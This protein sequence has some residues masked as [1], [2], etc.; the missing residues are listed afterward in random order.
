MRR[1]WQDWIA[2]AANLVFVVG[3]IPSIIGPNK[4]D[5][6]TSLLTGAALCGILATNVSKRWWMASV[7]CAANITGW[8]ILAVQAS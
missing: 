4:P 5:V 6:V 2:A 8:F 7:L 3:L 1:P